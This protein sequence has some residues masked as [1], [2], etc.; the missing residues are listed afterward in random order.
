MEKITKWM[1]IPPTQDIN[2]RVF[3]LMGK[4]GTGKTFLIG[5]ALKK[6]IKKDENLNFNPYKLSMFSLPN[7]LGVSMSH[8]AKNVLSRSIPNSTTFASY[9]GLKLNFTPDGRK[10]FT[11]KPPRKG[12]PNLCDVAI[13][14]VVHD[15][16]GVYDEG[17]ISKVLSQTNPKCKII[18]MGDPGQLPPINGDNSEKDSPAFYLPLEE[19]SRHTLTE[20]VRQTEG[21]P[22]IDLSDVIYNEIFGSKNIS[23]VLSLLRE[24]KFSGKEG[25]SFV[26]YEDYLEEFCS[27]D[28][29]LDVKSIAYRNNT[30]NDINYQ[31]RNSLHKTNKLFTDNEVVYF[32]ET[33]KSNRDL[34][35]NSEDYIIRKVTTENYKGYKCYLF[36]VRKDNDMSKSPDI[37][38]YAIHEDSYLKFEKDKNKLYGE[39][40]EK[41]G[42]EKKV[43]FAIYFSFIETFADL[44]Y[45]YAF[46][47][48]K[49]QGSTY[50]KV[51]IDVNDILLTKPINDKRK[52]QAIYTA[53]TRASEHAKFIKSNR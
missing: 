18:L 15:E 9:F 2:S 20:R 33:Y 42:K 26:K 53:L 31:V 36:W 40:L 30:V 47:N 3:L 8:K 17:M 19:R 25:Y 44:S 1:E 27:E 21:N 23:N 13:K 35:Y 10:V 16:V 48:Y 5:Q 41:T 45:G 7:V 4:A 29:F 14:F 52:L 6:L 43:A 34:C 22:I 46:T 24:P 28:N 50:K 39:A 11:A 32:N 12:F 51:Y 38:V 37:P 49:I